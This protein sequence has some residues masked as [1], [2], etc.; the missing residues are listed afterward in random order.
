MKAY[1]RNHLLI[2]STAMLGA[3]LALAAPAHAQR[4]GGG[5]VY[6]NLSGAGTLDP[7]V[8][9]NVVELEMIHHAYEALVEMGETY[10]A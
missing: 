5:I 10:D 7:H 2:G 9:A 1:S 8:A 6:A 4:K 3:A